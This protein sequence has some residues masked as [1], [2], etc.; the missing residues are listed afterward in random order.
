M[1]TPAADGAS[2]SHDDG[3]TAAAAASGDADLLADV[4]G[5]V[6]SCGGLYEQRLGLQIGESDTDE[7]SPRKAAP[8]QS[9]VAALSSSRGEAA[10]E[11]DQTRVVEISCLDELSGRTQSLELRCETTS[12]LLTHVCV[13]FGRAEEDMALEAAG[14]VVWAAGWSR[15]HVA[16]S[17]LSLG[18]VVLRR[19]LERALAVAAGGEHDTLPAWAWAERSVVREAVR[20]KCSSLQKASADLR[21]DREV[22]LE[23]VRHSGDAL[24]YTGECCRHDRAVVLEAVKQSGDA[25]QY[26]DAKCR[27]DREVILEAVRH[28]GSALQY[29]GEKLCADRD[30]VLA[31]VKLSSDALQYACERLRSDPELVAAAEAPRRAAGDADPATDA[32]SLRSSDAEA[33]CATQDAAGAH[34]PSAPFGSEDD[35]EDGGDDAGSRRRAHCPFGEAGGGG[36]GDDGSSVASSSG[37]CAGA[38]TTGD[39]A[40]AAADSALTCMARTLA[41][42]ADSA[43]RVDG[44]DDLLRYVR[45]AQAATGAASDA[46]AGGD[47]AR[48]VWGCVSTTRLCSED[49]KVTVS[50]AKE[51]GVRQA[52]F[53]NATSSFQ[54]FRGSVDAAV[55]VVAALCYADAEVGC[56]VEVDDDDSL[57]LFL[58]RAT[59]ERCFRLTAHR[60]RPSGGPSTVPAADRHAVHSEFCSGGAAAGDGLGPVDTRAAPHTTRAPVFSVLPV[61]RRSLAAA[62]AKRRPDPAAAAGPP[63]GSQAGSFG[64]R[65]YAYQQYHTQRASVCSVGG[66]G[67]GGGGGAP[68]GRVLS[69]S[70][71]AGAPLHRRRSSASSAASSNIRAFTGG[72]AI[73]PRYRDGG[74]GGSSLRSSRVGSQQ[75]LA[76]SL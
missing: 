15:A 55:G 74:G 51:P 37:A 73:I 35:E 53:L 57:S 18:D 36:G 33:A 8:A 62:D 72:A 50:V 10:A 42:S 29:A 31:A 63:T 67:G 3:R 24:Q 19:S 13:L 28:S 68:L 38:R 58:E 69:S 64:S 34:R 59:A 23:A 25:L 66:S 43:V 14:E 70:Q 46:G 17:G 65:G 49:V 4:D 2:T 41:D 48:R 26:A 27:H 76:Q 11:G 60:V 6:E 52:F 9:T 20:E 5:I 12:Q 75:A 1:A 61:P 39:A 45:E 22:A 7:M 16:V 44:D 21:N 47:A 71:H 54:G 30:L 56:D 32:S 40:A